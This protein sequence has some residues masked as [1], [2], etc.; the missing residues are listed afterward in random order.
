MTAKSLR[1]C[2]QVAAHSRSDLAWYVHVSLL[3]WHSYL[4]G[5]SRDTWQAQVGTQSQSLEYAL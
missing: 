4:E 5:R 2:W 1:L 3:M